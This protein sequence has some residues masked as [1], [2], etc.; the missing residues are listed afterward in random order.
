MHT[1]VHACVCCMCRCPHPWVHANS[2]EDQMSYSTVLCLLPWKQS[3]SVKLELVWR[4]VSHSNPPV[5]A[6]FSAGVTDIHSHRW[7]F[8]W[9][10]GFCTHLLMPP[11]QVLIPTEPSPPLALD[12][13]LYT[14]Y[15]RNTSLKSQIKTIYCY[16]LQ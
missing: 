5:C 4:S 15:Q 11:Q 1:G 9:V 2:R 13:L 14:N 7:L 12:M 10:L 8:M 3:I 6:T 16:I